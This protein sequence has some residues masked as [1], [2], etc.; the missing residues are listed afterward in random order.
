MG[1]RIQPKSKGGRP[2]K[3]QEKA[4]LLAKRPC[5]VCN[6]SEYREMSF[7]LHL[8]THT[9]K[10][11]MNTV[12]EIDKRTSE[13]P[14]CKKWLKVGTIFSQHGCTRKLA[15]FQK[16]MGI[17]YEDALKKILEK[18]PLGASGSGAK[19]RTRQDVKKEDEENFGR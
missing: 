12:D 10:K 6:S 9:K 3:G 18:T 17:T 15:L 11:F 1:D 14:I 19:K 13:C 4:Q 7:L 5:P 8:N 16:N 2:E